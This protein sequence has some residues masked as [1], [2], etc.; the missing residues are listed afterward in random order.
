MPLIHRYSSLSLDPSNHL[1]YFHMA[2]QMAMIRKVSW[3][4]VMMIMMLVVMVVV[5]MMM[6]MVF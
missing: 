1:T 4:V 2:H 3:F 6:V 5:V